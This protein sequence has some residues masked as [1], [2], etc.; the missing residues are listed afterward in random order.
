LPCRRG[1]PVARSAAVTVR[2]YFLLAMCLFPEPSSQRA[3]GKLTARL[4]V[5]GISVPS[6]R[7]LR[8]LRR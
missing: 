8:D 5:L 6:A 7:A 1:G 3:W 2:L 4:R